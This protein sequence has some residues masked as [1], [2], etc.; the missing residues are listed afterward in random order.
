MSDNAEGERMTDFMQ[1]AMRDAWG[2]TT[3]RYPCHQCG[4][5]RS[6]DE[7]GT[8][9]SVCDRCWA[10]AYPPLAGAHPG[11]AQ[12]AAPGWPVTDDMHRAACGLVDHC[13]LTGVLD[14]ARIARIARL[15]FHAMVDALP[16]LKE[17]G[18]DYVRVAGRGEV[19]YRST[20]HAL[21]PEGK[22]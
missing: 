8:T 18:G 3:R 10:A 11:D 6:R 13:A 16:R 19:I 2:A 7:G 12:K 9:F 5:L 22:P 14:S 15:G 20:L 1:D 17:Y 21:D 4:T